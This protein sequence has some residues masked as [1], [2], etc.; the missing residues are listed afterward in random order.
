M[1]MLFG[2]DGKVAAN[3]IPATFRSE[4]YD[5]T[6]YTGWGDISLGMQLLPIIEM[7]MKGNLFPT[8]AY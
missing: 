7:H 6:T 2:P 3:L 4:G 1:A 8:L 5:L